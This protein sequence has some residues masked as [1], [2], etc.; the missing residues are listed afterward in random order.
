MS[1]D[2]PKQPFE[3]LPGRAFLDTNVVNFILDHGDQIHQSVP[4]DPSLPARV[5]WDIDALR[6]IF[7]TGQR[8]FWQFAVSPLTYR[9]VT[10]TDNPQRRHYL[11]TWFAELWDY[12][13]ETMRNANDLPSFLAAE[14]M[15][16]QLWASDV[17]A[18]LPDL[19]DRVLICDAIVY[20]CDCFCTRD[21]ESILKHRDML[22]DL[23]IRIIT[24]RE[25]WSEIQPWAGIWC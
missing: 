2:C 5:Q 24:P 7:E 23:P 21:W 10:A 17:L 9:E 1:S 3:S 20:K 16:L 25:W 18:I 4:C 12:W 22:R 19:A 14:E 8:A 6:G 15:R 13:R 11:E